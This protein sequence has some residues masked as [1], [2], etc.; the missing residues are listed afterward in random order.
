MNESGSGGHVAVDAHAHGATYREVYTSTPKM[1][2]TYRR[3]LFARKPG[4]M[5]G[6]PMPRI[7]TALP[8]VDAEPER[9]AAYRALCGFPADGHLPITWPQVL[10]GP[11]HGEIIT[12]PRFPLRAMGLVHLSL[13]HISEPTRPY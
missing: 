13:I 2:A 4:L 11:L 10:A 9:L 12:H 3:A 7:E 8:N 1:T 5:P 6:V